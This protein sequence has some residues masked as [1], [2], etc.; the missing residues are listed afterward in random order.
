MYH[1]DTC[2]II[3]IN[4]IFIVKLVTRLALSKCIRGSDTVVVF[5]CTFTYAN[6]SLIDTN[7]RYITR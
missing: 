5:I 4:R 7:F 2:Y 3:T 1:S 6:I